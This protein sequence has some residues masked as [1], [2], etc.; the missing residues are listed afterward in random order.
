MAN[1]PFCTNLCGGDV[2][3]RVDRLPCKWWHGSAH[4]DMPAHLSRVLFNTCGC[5]FTLLW[6]CISFLFDVLFILA[7]E[8]GRFLRSQMLCEVDEASGGD[9]GAVIV[10]AWFIYSQR[11]FL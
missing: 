3:S 1:R 4:L 5:L 7:V 9:K 10:L 11:R 6:Y 2:L 8:A